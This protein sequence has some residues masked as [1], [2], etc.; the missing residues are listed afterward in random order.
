MQIFQQFVNDRLDLLNMGNGFSDE[1]ETE[2]N[3]YGDK[4]GAKSRYKDW[5]SHMKVSVAI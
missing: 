1:F 2:A 3:I 4:W 5:L